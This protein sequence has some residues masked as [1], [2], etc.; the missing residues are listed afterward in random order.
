MASPKW[1]LAFPGLTTVT[2][3]TLTFIKCLMGYYNLRTFTWLTK[4]NW[5]TLLTTFPWHHRTP[6]F[7]RPHSSLLQ[8]LKAHEHARPFQPLCLH[9]RAEPAQNGSCASPILPLPSKPSSPR[10]PWQRNPQKQDSFQGN[11]SMCRSWAALGQ[12]PHHTFLW[13]S[14]HLAEATAILSVTGNKYL[15]CA[16]AMKERDGKTWPH[17]AALHIWI[18]YGTLIHIMKCTGLD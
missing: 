1:N 4:Q 7:P 6:L 5:I 13:M 18:L 9:G 10:A 11:E 16:T 8:G 12:R 14:G 17:W 15:A 3:Y 2:A